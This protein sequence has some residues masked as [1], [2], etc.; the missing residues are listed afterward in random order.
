[1]RKAAS[2]AFNR[3]R[4]SSLRSSG[5]ASSSPTICSV[6]GSARPPV[7]A[8]G[9]AMEGR[10]RASDRASGAR[11]PSSTRHRRAAPQPH[12]GPPGSGASGL[13]LDLGPQSVVEL[14]VEHAIVER[15]GAVEVES[16]RCAPRGVA[17]AR[18]DLADRRQRNRPS[19]CTATSASHRPR[20]RERRH[21]VG[22][23]RTGWAPSETRRRRAARAG[24]AKR[25]EDTVRPLR[26]RSA[27]MAASADCNASARGCPA[28]AA[29]ASSVK[30][31]AEDRAG[32]DEGLRFGWQMAEPRADQV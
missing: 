27:R 26:S 25:S 20:P 23:A 6:V 16:P 10:P 13:D 1:M 18:D 4:S 24:C 15:D 12:R 7:G 19:Q 5:W 3:A 21:N 31:W 28:T 2:R 29:A 32:L 11:A 30:V 8:R 17:R 9:A 14:D 22:G